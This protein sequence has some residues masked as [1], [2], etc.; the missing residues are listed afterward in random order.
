MQFF[1]DV[2]VKNNHSPATTFLLPSERLALSLNYNLSLCLRH[3]FRIP[4][5]V[6]AGLFLSLALALSRVCIFGLGCCGQS[7]PP[8][9]SSAL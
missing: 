8:A 3:V 7:H 5:Q 6:K 1:W 4:A 2:Q 9:S